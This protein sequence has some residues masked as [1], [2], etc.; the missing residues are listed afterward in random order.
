MYI[1]FPSEMQWVA[2]Y[3]RERLI[4]FAKKI[5]QKIH[6][7]SFLFVI[8]PFCINKNNTI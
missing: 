2:N 4:M 7:L 3:C 6:D 8:L 5:R 1:K